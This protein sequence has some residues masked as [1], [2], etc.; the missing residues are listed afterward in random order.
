MVEKDCKFYRKESRFLTSAA[1]VEAAAIS[2][3]RATL[4][5]ILFVVDTT[6]LKAAFQRTVSASGWAESGLFTAE[7]SR[8]LKLSDGEAAQLLGVGSPDQRRVG[9]TRTRTQTRSI[10]QTRRI[11][12]QIRKNSRKNDR[13]AISHTSWTQIIYC[14]IS[15]NDLYNDIKPTQ[16]IST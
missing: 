11:V 8:C 4:R 9:L 14:F 5:P 6:L 1:R 13:K 12:H 2:S 15:R 16:P 3:S 10:T 7:D